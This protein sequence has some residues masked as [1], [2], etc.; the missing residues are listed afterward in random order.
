VK[1]LH[2]CPYCGCHLQTVSHNESWFEKYC[3]DRCKMKYHQYHVS[4]FQD[5][6]LRYITFDTGRFNV[7]VYFEK[8]YYPNK[9]H[10]YSH[11]EME[12]HG[13]AMPVVDDLPSDRIPTNELEEIVITNPGHDHSSQ[14][15]AWLDK[16][17]KKLYTLALFT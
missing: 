2:N 1:A 8:G 3:Q 14:I 4:S 7:Y 15:Q 10:F 6:E 13:K 11:Q 5:E 9:I 12:I 17:D 16:I